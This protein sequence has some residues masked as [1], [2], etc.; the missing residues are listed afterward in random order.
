MLDEDVAA[1]LKAEAC[2]TKKPLNHVVNECLRRGL[3]LGDQKERRSP[4]RIVPRDLGSLKPGLSL[5]K[6]GELLEAVEGSLRP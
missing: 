4:F 2:R 6:I 3:V 5:D 1:R